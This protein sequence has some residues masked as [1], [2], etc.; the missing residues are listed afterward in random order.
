MPARSWSH[1][2]CSSFGFEGT[3]MEMM[4]NLWRRK[5]RT[6]LTVSGIV[7]GIFALTTMG[8][9]AEHFNVLLGGGITYYGG[10]IQVTDDKSN[11]GFGA[12]ALTLDT[13]HKIQQVRGVVAAGPSVS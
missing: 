11:G 12:G 1:G 6:V 3:A 9:L 5:L 13:L 10:S 4:R 8:S 7:M 2:D